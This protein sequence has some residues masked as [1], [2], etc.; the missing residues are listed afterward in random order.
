MTFIEDKFNITQK[1]NEMIIEE[2]RATRKQPMEK[3]FQLHFLSETG[4]LEELNLPADNE[5]VQF[6]KSVIDKN[7]TVFKQQIRDLTIRGSN[8]YS[9]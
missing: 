1:H 2:I 9:G 8:A 5:V 7:H 3:P 6:H 4:K